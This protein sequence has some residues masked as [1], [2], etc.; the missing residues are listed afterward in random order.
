LSNV[1]AGPNADV[2]VHAIHYAAY[3]Y[4]LV[5]WRRRQLSLNQSNQHLAPAARRQ[6][7]GGF[8]VLWVLD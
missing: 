3:D 7:V 4:A 8:F 6:L 2:V 5:F 1:E